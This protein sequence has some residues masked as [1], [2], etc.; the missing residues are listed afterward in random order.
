VSE[1]PNSELI[2]QFALQKLRTRKTVV[3]RSLNRYGR[4][5]SRPSIA[6]LVFAK[7]TWRRDRNLSARLNSCSKNVYSNST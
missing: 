1:S 2:G 7:S 4:S 6:N 5:P 3:K